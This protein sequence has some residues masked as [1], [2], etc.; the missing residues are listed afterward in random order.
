[1]KR[2][3]VVLISTV[4]A[5]ALTGC[6]VNL[7][8]S[9]DGAASAN[10]DIISIEDGST[11]E[12]PENVVGMPN[13]MVEIVDDGDYEAKLGIPID[14]SFLPKENF[15]MYIIGDSLADVRFDVTNV[16]GENVNCMLRATKSDAD[17]LNPY[18]LIAGIYATDF[19]EEISE[20]YP[21]DN[22]NITMRSVDSASSNCHIT[23]W[24]YSG[25]H[26]TFTVEGTT[27]Q[28]QL[29]A[30]Y[31]SI[32]L[33]IG[34]DNIARS[35][36]GPLDETLDV[37]NIEGGVYYAKMENVETD[38]NGT[39]ADFT[40][41][42]EDLYDAVDLNSLQPGDTLKARSSSADEFAEYEI[43]TIEHKEVEFTEREIAMGMRVPEAGKYDVILING[44]LDKIDE[45]GFEFIAN[46][47]GTYKFFGL[48]NY[49]TYTQ[50]GTVNLL[51][52][53][54]AEIID[55]SEDWASSEAEP[56]G[57]SIRAT[58]LMSFCAED[59]GGFYCTNTTITVE[60][61]VVT[62]IIRSYAP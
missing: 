45:G 43:K 50:Q 10:P 11:D 18:E 5:I 12:V 25:A 33:A 44:G 60:D 62:K 35:V 2:K 1:M 3:V 40:I 19:T 56:A 38:E 51:I 28:M 31:D 53:E 52:A 24:D 9:N 26:Y 36:V 8:V 6:N 32:M 49:A 17:A 47:G 41:Y 14:T 57:K 20:D 39:I 4:A 42:T 34:A 59:N 23:T 21:A 46:E 30:L 29:G 48:D 7:N 61:G 16:D 27:S 54:D 13:P 55:H 58:E 37:K 22:G 15:E